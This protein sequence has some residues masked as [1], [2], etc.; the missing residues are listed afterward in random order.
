MLEV[1]EVE[2]AK[3]T[4]DWRDGTH[5]VE[6][7]EADGANGQE[8]RSQLGEE[9]GTFWIR[10]ALVHFSDW[11]LLE[12]LVSDEV[13]VGVSARAAPGMLE[14]GVLQ[15]RSDSGSPGKWLERFM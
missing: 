2:V 8:H 7:T 11:V 6:V 3:R 9:D 10:A 1:V 14:T 15:S 12:Q 4:E 13:L 5:S